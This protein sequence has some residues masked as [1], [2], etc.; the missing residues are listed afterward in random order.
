MFAMDL[1]NRNQ[2]LFALKTIYRL[3]LKIIDKFYSYYYYLSLQILLLKVFIY[4][5]KE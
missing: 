2:T 4:E 1:V 5:I 3:L